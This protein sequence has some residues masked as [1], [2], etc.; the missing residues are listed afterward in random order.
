MALVAAATVTVGGALYA[1][2]RQVDHHQPEPPPPPPPSNIDRAKELR[3]NAAVACEAKD[4]E[5]CLRDLKEAKELDPAGDSDPAV[6]SLRRNARTRLSLPE[7]KSD[8]VP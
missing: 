2:T 4:Y 3:K 7:D 1:L 5:G 8:K 6:R